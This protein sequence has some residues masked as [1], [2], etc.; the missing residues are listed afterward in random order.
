[1]GQRGVVVRLVRLAGAG[2]AFLAASAAAS[3]SSA[4]LARRRA[5]SRIVL[6]S[7]AALAAA[8][9]AFTS[10]VRRSHTWNTPS[11]ERSAVFLVLD[12]EMG[13]SFA[14]GEQRRCA[15]APPPQIVRRPKDWRPWSRAH[16]AG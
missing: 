3:A 1:M 2:G 16:P 13:L 11:G 6:A 12:S 7:V 8:R 15:N 9:S 5:R 4:S 14:K 10:W